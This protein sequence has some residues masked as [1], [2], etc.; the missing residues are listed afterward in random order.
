VKRIYGE[1]VRELIHPQPSCALAGDHRSEKKTWTRRVPAAGA[2]GRSGLIKTANW[3]R[4]CNDLNL[5]ELPVFFW[6]GWVD[7][8]IEIGGGRLQFYLVPGLG[9]GGGG[10][11]GGVGWGGGPATYSVRRNVSFDCTG[12]TVSIFHSSRLTTCSV[13][14]EWRVHLQ[15]AVTRLPC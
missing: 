10:G 3:C 12:G 8:M 11:G 13:R 4:W 6:V 1:P 15:L 2:W 5:L 14:R 7:L 9:G